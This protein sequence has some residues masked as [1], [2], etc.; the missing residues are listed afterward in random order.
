MGRGGCKLAGRKSR[1]NLQGESREGPGRHRGRID[2]GRATA[3]FW[4]DGPPRSLSHLIGIIL[5]TRAVRRLC[6]YEIKGVWA[7]MF[8]ADDGTPHRALGDRPPA[9]EARAVPTLTPLPRPALALGAG[10]S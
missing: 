10:L 2:R 3:P 9:P 5:A 8:A 7:A 4:G 6:R 1:G